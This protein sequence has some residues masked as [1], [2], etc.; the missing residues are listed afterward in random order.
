MNVKIRWLFHYVS[1]LSLHSLRYRRR[2]IFG[3]ILHICVRN[4]V[5]LSIGIICEKGRPRE[6]YYPPEVYEG[7]Y[8]DDGAYYSLR[9]Q[10][11][12]IGNFTFS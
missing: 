12:A 11:S 4:T 2:R 6:R 8:D 10:T 5:V 3:D 7:V 9:K 1:P